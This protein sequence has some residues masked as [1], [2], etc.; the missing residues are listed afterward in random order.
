M[1]LSGLPGRGTHRPGPRLC[2]LPCCRSA[3]P[4]CRHRGRAAQL[5]GGSG[6]GWARA[7]G[8][9]GGRRGWAW[10]GC[11]RDGLRAPEPQGAPALQRRSEKAL[12]RSPGTALSC[13]LIIAQSR[14]EPSSSSPAS[15]VWNLSFVHAAFPASTSL[16]WQ[17]C[18]CVLVCTCCC[19]PLVYLLPSGSL[20]ICCVASVCVEPRSAKGGV[21]RMGRSVQGFRGQENESSEMYA[22]P[23]GKGLTG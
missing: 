8:G 10:R 4:L 21:W 16:I 22:K 20:S 1:G 23:D 3:R 18:A 17:G 6:G 19:A 14:G 2:C 9:G 13:W 5:R 15:T 7:R 11:R 12:Q